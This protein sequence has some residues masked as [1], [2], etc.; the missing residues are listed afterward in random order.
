MERTGGPEVLTWA[1]LPDPVPGNGELLVRL[2][3]AGVNFIDT[4]HREGLYP[5]ELPFVPGVE[6][7]GTV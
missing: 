1:E 4:Y 5:R 2:G 7:A 3:A 6:G